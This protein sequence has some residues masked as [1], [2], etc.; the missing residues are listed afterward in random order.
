MADPRHRVEEK[1]GAERVDPSHIGEGNN[2]KRCVRQGHRF[3]VRRFVCNLMPMVYARFVPQCDEHCRRQPLT[4][5]DSQR[6][7]SRPRLGRGGGPSWREDRRRC[8]SRLF[9]E[10]RS[11]G[12]GA[13]EAGGSPRVL[14]KLGF[15][16]VGI[17][18]TS[19]VRSARFRRVAGSTCEHASPSEPR[20]RASEARNQMSDCS[21]RASQ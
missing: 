1:E 4:A 20:L 21:T 16:G 14:N 13:S 3:V 2:R 11:E 19:T 5:D 6:V 7:L 18:A 9:S 8:T 15:G 10:C 17:M 12:G